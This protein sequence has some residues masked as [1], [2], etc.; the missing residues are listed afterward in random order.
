MLFVQGVHVGLM[1][2]EG[3]MYYLLKKKAENNGDNNT[4]YYT[5]NLN[6]GQLK[7]SIFISFLLHCII[8][9]NRKKSLQIK[10]IPLLMDL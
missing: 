4:I 8:M 1:A 9:K 5:W 2:R 7:Q 6:S 10:D 3:D